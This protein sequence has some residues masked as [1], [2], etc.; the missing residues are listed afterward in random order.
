MQIITQQNLSLNRN[1]NSISL[2]FYFIIA[3]TMV[4]YNL[5]HFLVYGPDILLGPCQW[6][7]CLDYLCIIRSE[8]SDQHKVQPLQVFEEQ[9]QDSIRILNYDLKTIFLNLLKSRTKH[10]LK[11]ISN[12]HKNTMVLELARVYSHL[13][14]NNI[15]QGMYSSPPLSIGGRSQDPQ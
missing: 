4:F 15:L 11:N 6:G 1:R 13:V 9:M 14:W 2:H 3:L 8:Y 5:C 7:P 10:L 12:H